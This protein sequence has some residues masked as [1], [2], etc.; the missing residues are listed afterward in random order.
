MINGSIA[1]LITPFKENGDIDFEC[2]GRI[3]DFHIQNGTDGI[4]VLGTTGEAP[5]VNDAE[6]EALISFAVK[7]ANGKI[8]VIAGC[9]SNDTLRAK[10]RCLIAEKL[11]ADTILLLTPYYNKAN[12]EGMIRHFTLCAD[13]IHTP[14]IIY[15]VPPRTGCSIGIKE[16]EILKKHENIAGIKEASGNMG[17]FTRV[18]TLSDENFG[19]YCGCDEINVPALSVGACGIISV[20]AN[21]LPRECSEMVRNMTSGKRD[22]AK[23]LQ[24]RYTALI[25]ALFSEPNPIP[26]KTAM[27]MLRFT[28]IGDVGT[29]R[30]PLC[31]MAED[32]RLILKNELENII[33]DFEK[34][35]VKRLC[36]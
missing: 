15:N 14:I 12:S 26:I 17:F 23:E 5:T 3:I 2:Y 34:Y 11:G 21:I 30:L 29:F 32:T 6:T 31:K 8:P 27:N 35:G 28:S 19:V 13:S 25:R 36:E 18:C 24:L 4:V 16:L 1:A 7:H 9:G 20:L 33:A 10:K 22:K